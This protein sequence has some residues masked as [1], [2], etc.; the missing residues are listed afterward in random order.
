MPITPQMAEQTIAERLMPLPIEVRPLERCVG[1]TLRQDVYAERDNPPFDRVCMDGIAIRSEGGGRLR[2]VLEATQRAGAPAASLSN[3]ASAVEVM[4]GAI[5]PRGTDCVIPLE[6]YD[7]MDNVVVLKDN[8][9]VNPY[10]NVQRRGEDSEPGV[11]MLRIGTR[12]GAPELAV[13]AS[14]GLASVRVSAQP[15]FMIISTGDELVEPGQPIAEHQVRRSNVYAVVAALREHGFERVGNDHIADDEDLLRARLARHLDEYEVTVLSGGISKG[16][17]DLVP[18]ALKSLGVEEIFNQVAQ[19]P[20]MPMWFGTGT[21]GQAVFGLPG[22]PVSTLMCLVRY[23]IPAVASAMS[24]ALRTA[25]MVGLAEALMLGRKVASF[26]PVVLRQDAMGGVAAVPRP[27][28]GSGDFLSLA[29]TD[30]FIELPPRP[31]PFPA[32]FVARLYRW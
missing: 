16:R 24:T 19:R 14:A 31:D 4:T 13:V 22:N 3:P 10:R 29:G 20:G 1:R 26:V 32:G 18:Q 15:A 6:E 17:F 5:L 8:A 21:R 7:V 11:P 23:V 27:P 9:L 30:G 28:N 12:L 2:F 25:E